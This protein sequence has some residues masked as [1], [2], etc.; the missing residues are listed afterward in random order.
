MSSIDDPSLVGYIFFRSKTNDEVFRDCL[1]EARKYIKKWGMKKKGVV[2]LFLPENW[3]GE[4]PKKLAEGENRIEIVEK[5][6]IRDHVVLNLNY[7]TQV[8]SIDYKEDLN[9]EE[10]WKTFD[11][12]FTQ[13]E[14]GVY[15]IKIWYGIMSDGDHPNVLPDY[16]YD[17]TD[18]FHLY[19][20]RPTYPGGN[21]LVQEIYLFVRGYNNQN[22]SNR[23]I[24]YNLL[25]FLYH[26]L[27]ANYFFSETE[28]YRAEVEENADDYMDTVNKPLEDLPEEEQINYLYK[29]QMEYQ[30]FMQI[31]SNFIYSKNTIQIHRHNLENPKFDFIQGV[32]NSVLNELNYYINQIDSNL[33]YMHSFT[34]KQENKM[35]ILKSN[36]DILNATERKE[37][38][39]KIKDI[40]SSRLEMR[41]SAHVIEFFIVLYY[42]THIWE[43]VDPA[44]YEA[45]PGWFIFLFAIL[46]S[47]TFTFG[48][49][50]K[51]IK[52]FYKKEREKKE[53]EKR[54]VGFLLFYFLII[55]GI[56]L[57]IYC[58]PRIIYP[59]VHASI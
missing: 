17:E 1:E 4:D 45:V 24:N 13:V 27:T 28:Y 46:F 49:T 43:V 47:G 48:F 34:E 10:V 18:D 12:Y 38:F 53:S 54:T 29:I 8:V 7:D 9:P 40:Q 32:K 2:K 25:P 39:R 30:H 42:F 35:D 50:E 3:E 16:I 36:I 5:H 44:G 20:Y 52:L 31:K 6:G 22:D 23:F 57:I 41:K 19:Y 55:M 14:R 56:T 37:I 21:E 15:Y 51:L 26:Y 58:F 11:D 59:S 33:N